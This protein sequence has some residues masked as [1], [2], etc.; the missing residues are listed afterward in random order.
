[1]A[2]S[3]AHGLGRDHMLPT[4]VTCVLVSGFSSPILERKDK[5][6]FSPAPHPTAQPRA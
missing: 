5:H 3:V 6:Q 4:V 2:G 1:M